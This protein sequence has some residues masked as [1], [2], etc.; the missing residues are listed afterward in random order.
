MGDSFLVYLRSARVLGLR[1]CQVLLGD[2]AR[3]H[4]TES[5]DVE[6]VGS[7]RNPR[8]RYRASA[9]HWRSVTDDIGLRAGTSVRGGCFF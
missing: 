4:F 3:P 1:H 9:T 7:R 8:L 5:G 6:P 2:M